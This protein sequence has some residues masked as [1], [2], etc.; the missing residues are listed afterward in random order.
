MKE[1][2]R[3]IAESPPAVPK[4]QAGR[5]LDFHDARSGPHDVLTEAEA[6]R[7]TARISRKLS[8]IVDNT[9][10]VM[11]LIREAIGRN[12]YAALG[13]ASHGAYVAERFGDT[14]S[15]LKVAQRRDV[16]RELTAT[17]MSNRAAGAVL[18]VHEK[19]VRND[20]RAGAELSA[21]DL[22]LKSIG[23][24]GKAYARSTR[25]PKIGDLPRDE[26]TERRAGL[27]RR[28]G[29]DADDIARAIKT[30]TDLNADRRHRVRDRYRPVDKLSR[31][32]LEA[33]AT[34]LYALA[35]DLEGSSSS[36]RTGAP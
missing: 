28:I 10:A 23:Q 19:T 22:S 25:A 29:K 36:P 3:S 13:Y 21:P 27:A 7:L 5:D 26:E 31:E 32:N 16:V 8:L 34:N 30:L 20:L 18:G 11:P 2:E 9:E 6:E 4:P 24:D 1:Q 33:I 15:R 14:L 17:G 35:D 12:A